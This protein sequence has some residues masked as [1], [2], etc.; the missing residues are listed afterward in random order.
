MAECMDDA[1]R[2]NDGGVFHHQRGQSV[3]FENVV[4][5]VGT[6]GHYERVW[7]EVEEPGGMRVD[8]HGMPGCWNDGPAAGGV[9]DVWGVG[10]D[11]GKEV[12]VAWGY[13]VGG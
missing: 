10:C 12:G 6:R 2:R 8:G 5:E 11:I 1:I 13:V 9:A 4:I 7:G 3:R